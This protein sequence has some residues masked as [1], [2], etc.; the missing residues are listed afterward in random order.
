MTTPANRGRASPERAAFP[1]PYRSGK[2]GSILR[3]VGHLLRRLPCEDVRHDQPAAPPGA[4]G[5]LHFRADGE[6]ART[7]V[8]VCF[9]NVE[10][11]A[12]NIGCNEATA[13]GRVNPRD[14]SG[15]HVRFYFAA[16]KTRTGSRSARCS[17][18]DSQKL[19]LCAS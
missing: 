14:R 17:S 16:R 11:P 18:V 8:D 19:F 13:P 10:I 9:L 12:W 15:R 2:L 5:E 4:D 3:A 1:F 6:R 7:G